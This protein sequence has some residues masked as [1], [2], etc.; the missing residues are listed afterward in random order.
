M[1]KTEIP[2]AAR[3]LNVSWIESVEKTLDELGN[4]T[5]VTQ[6]MKAAGQKCAEAILA[7]CEEILGKKPETVDELLE[8][9]NRRRLQK[10]NLDNPWERKGN[11]AHL[12]IDECGCTLVKAGLAKPNPV[13]CLCS[14]GLWEN[15]FSKVC[16]GPV[17]VEITKA[18]GFGDHECEFYVDFEE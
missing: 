15:L 16:R 10:L 3:D 13:H 6:I 1:K 7:D 12:V 11:R 18:V 17:K 14:A 8:A 9:N 2:E 5:L 4:P